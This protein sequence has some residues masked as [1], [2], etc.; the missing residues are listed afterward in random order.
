MSINEWDE[1]PDQEY[2]ENL[3]LGLPNKDDGC[4]GYS[5]FNG[6]STEYDCDYEFAGDI[7]C[8]DCIFGPCEGT[9]D[10][11]VDPSEDDEEGCPQCKHNEVCTGGC[12]SEWSDR[13]PYKFELKEEAE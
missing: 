5:T 11:R 3:E 8:E 1:I 2:E 6:E 9:R 4:K 7:N 13:P 12:E 10:P